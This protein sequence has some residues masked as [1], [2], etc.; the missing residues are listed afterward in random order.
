MSLDKITIE[1]ISYKFIKKYNTYINHYKIKFNQQPSNY[2]ST[3][4][5]L[6]DTISEVLSKFKENAENDDK[7]KIFISHPE[8]SHPISLPFLDKDDLTVEMIVNQI[9]KVLQS[10]RKLEFDDK[11]TFTTSLLKIPRGSGRLDNFIIRKQ[12]IV[13]VKDEKDNL[14][15]L[16]AIVIAKALADKDILLYNKIRDSRNNLQTIEARKLAFSLGF[17][18]NTPVGLKEIEIVEK[19]LNEYQIIVIDS[20]MLN[21]IVYMGNEKRKKLVLYIHNNHY[22]VIKSL[23]AFFNTK[24]FCMKCKSPYNKFHKHKCNKVC[25]RCNNKYCLEN[26]GNFKCEFCNLYCKNEICLAM[27][28][29]KV[30]GKITLCNICNK[31]NYYKHSCNGKYCRFCKEHV[32]EK[33][34]CYIK[35]DSLNAKSTSKGYV[36][37]DYEA[38]TVNGYHIPNLIVAHKKCKACTS[39]KNCNSECG[40]YIF[41]NNDDFCM[42]LFEQKNFTAIAHNMKSYDGYFL[43]QYI[44]KNVLPKEK[45]PEI[46]L[47]GS[48]I[49]VLKFSNVK[50]IDSI[51]FIPMALAKFPKTFGIKELKKGYFP[52]F[53]N[54][55]ENQQYV[56]PYPN[57]SFYGAEYMSNSDNENFF[58]WYHSKKEETFDFQKELLEYCRSDVEIL[59][60]SCLTFRELFMQITKLDDK[61]SGVDP[62]ESCLTIASACHLV[63]RRNF[64]PKNSIALIPDFGYNKSDKCS[65]KALIWLKY[66]S[67]SN[68]IFIHHAKN[69]KEKRI[70]NYKLDGWCEETQTAYEF[71]GCVYHGCKRCFTS[72]TFNPILNET[73]GKTYLKHVE[74]INF[75]KTKVKLVEIWECEY[76]EKLKNDIF[77]KEYVKS[78]R[79]IRPPLNPRS[80]LS[81]GRTNAIELYYRGSAGYIDFT[82]LYP[83]VQKYGQF[84]IGHPTIITE[85]F[86]SLDNYFG[87]V[88]CR[89]LPPQNLYIP[90]LPYHTN[91]KLMFPLCATCANTLS[92]DCNHLPHERELEGTWVI[93]EV[94]KAIEK[95][96]QITQIN[97]I[98]HFDET[99]VYN[100]EIQK[101]G[102][103]SDYVNTFLKI[104]QQAAGF[105][106]W[107]KSAEDK[108]KYIQ[109]F[110]KREGIQLEIDKVI[111]NNGLKAIAKLMLNSQWGRYAM[112]TNKTQSKF[113][114]E[115]LEVM[116]MFLNKQ[117]EIKDLVF[118][119][120]ELSI[121]FYENKAEMNWGSNQTNVILA[122][123]VTCQA[124]LKLYSELEKLDKRVLYF[125]TDSII[126]KKCDGCYEPPIGDFLGDFTNEIDP[127]EGN[128]IVEF[129]SAGPKNYAYRLDSGLSQCKVKGFTLNYSASKLIDFDK[130]KLIVS[131]NNEIKEH[132][133]QNTIVRNKKDWSLK[134]RNYLKVYRL[135]YDKRVILSDLTTIPYGYKL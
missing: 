27:H 86:K 24:F 39:N 97:E 4:E 82:S 41:Y 72:D 69:G 10:N 128:E 58:K 101:G 108:Q 132:I 18:D 122:A 88:Y 106:N 117:Y 51:N 87:L 130:I 12:S 125:D 16:R 28:L 105:P 78:I 20:I 31:L 3:I 73:M 93:L 121:I 21:N 13:Q 85:N 29:E 114:S 7:L 100:K 134:S 68:N 83:Y 104:K 67:I 95:G 44:V 109:N 79:H 94:L 75:I 133:E 43:L 96:Y 111:E 30:C 71:H 32:D 92:S 45:L 119:S 81:G 14:C 19:H 70:G 38:M 77:F 89:I 135:V 129:V 42:W 26:N 118:P 103:F 63:Y 116:R 113:I 124:R 60:Q 34:K 126:Y 99:S 74:R 48:K 120:D 40:E 50:V 59:M 91:N 76:E 5:Y 37:F 115:P 8:L 66:V 2:L 110:Y 15:A 112:Q 25:K 80:A 53:F 35:K 56:G 22:Y 57:P 17:S 64:M 33:H 84:P 90:L 47:N 62:F 123:F 98:W 9:S 36:F 23:P 46:L 107:V 49:L 102:L 11:I 127:S 52:H 1:S 6:H 131:K 54:L 65:Y 55:P 61:D